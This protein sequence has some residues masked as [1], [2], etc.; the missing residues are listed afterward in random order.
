MASG[1]TDRNSRGPDKVEDYRRP[2]IHPLV[3]HKQDTNPSGKAA[4]HKRGEESLPSKQFNQ[5]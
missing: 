3:A 5:F 1:D 4:A 2:A